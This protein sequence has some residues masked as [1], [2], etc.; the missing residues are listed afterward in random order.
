MVPDFK[1][2]PQ[3]LTK[4]RVVMVI[5]SFSAILI[6]VIFNLMKLYTDTN[7][8]LRRLDIM[9]SEIVDQKLYAKNMKYEASCKDLG[10]EYFPQTDFEIVDD[11]SYDTETLY[12]T[13]VYYPYDL[14][15]YEPECEIK[16][17]TWVAN[18]SWYDKDKFDW[19]R[20]VK[21]TIKK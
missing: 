4:L 21:E 12:F 9:E 20:E 18:T 10:G 3:P 5:L 15:R 13:I 2:Y 8:I 14:K 16:G 11:R 7:D 17:V 1:S 6:W 19:K